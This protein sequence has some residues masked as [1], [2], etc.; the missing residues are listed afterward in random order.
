MTWLWLVL[1]SLAVLRIVETMKEIVPWPMSGRGKSV[2]S[3]IIGIALSAWLNDD[4]KTTVLLGL[5]ATGLSMIF[6]ETRATL[7]YIGDRARL[8]V[9]RAGAERSRFGR[10]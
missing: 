5:G 10:L 6:H 3:I 8:D 7:S 2:L 9:I 4:V 1:I